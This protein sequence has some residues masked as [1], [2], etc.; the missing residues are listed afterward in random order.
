MNPRFALV[1]ILVSLTVL[2]VALVPSHRAR[3]Q[4]ERGVVVEIHGLHSNRG[5]VLGA[6]FASPGDWT[7]AGRQVAVCSSRIVSRRAYCVLDVPPGTYGFACFHDE[8]END[9]LDTNLFGLP[10]EGFGFSND[11]PTP[12]RA[13]SWEE[14][15][16]EHVDPVDVITVRIRYG[17]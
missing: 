7:I 16:F 15:R 14:V 8:N 6:L 11:A 13:P 1:S 5:R 2:T 12:M 17:L 9:T 4:S 3:S 10:D